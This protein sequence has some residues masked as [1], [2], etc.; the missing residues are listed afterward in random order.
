MTTAPAPTQP[1]HPG[2]NFDA[3]R[4]VAATMVLVSHHFALTGQLEPS[5]LGVH[6]YGGLAVAIFFIISGYLVAASWQRD[7]NLWRFTLRRFLCIW[8]ALTAVLILTAYGLGAWVTALPLKEYLTHGATANYLR[9]LWLNIHYVLP[10]VFEHNPY[11]LGVNGSLWTI[12][13]EVRCYIVLG[14]AGFIGLL[15]YRPV[16]LLCIGLYMLWFLASSNADLTGRVHYGRELSAFFLAGTALYVASRPIVWPQSS[17][18]QAS[19]YWH[20]C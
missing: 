9:G 19:P 13:L 3:I 1:T 18:R 6:S 16:L 11:P 4:I 8:L 17:S 10:G 7:P 14:L 12:P 2:N 15:K 20:A 5:F